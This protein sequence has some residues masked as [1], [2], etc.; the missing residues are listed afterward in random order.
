M[1]RNTTSQRIVPD[2]TKFPTGIEGL[3]TEIHALGLKVGIYRYGA[4]YP[5]LSY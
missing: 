2:P 5:V 3:A 1:K 4:F